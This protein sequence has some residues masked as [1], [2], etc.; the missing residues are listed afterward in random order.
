MK[1][2]S[3]CTNARLDLEPYREYCSLGLDKCHGCVMADLQTI[4]VTAK[5]LIEDARHETVMYDST[6]G[7]LERTW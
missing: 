4:R 2:Q 3:R 6:T 5:Q 1:I 7:K